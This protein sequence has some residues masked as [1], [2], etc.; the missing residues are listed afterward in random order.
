MGTAI[1]DSPL[2]AEPVR[3]PVYL[4]FSTPRRAA[5]AAGL[6]AAAGGPAHRRHGRID[7]TGV[8]NTFP[9]NPDLPLRSFT[10]AIDGGSGG[11]LQLGQDLCGPTTAD[12]DQGQADLALRQACREFKQELVDA[13]L[14]P[15]ARTCSAVKRGKFFTRGRRAALGRARGPAITSAPPGAARRAWC[16]ASARRAIHAGGRQ[17]RRQDDPK[18]TRREGPS[19]CRALGVSRS[20]GAAWLPSASSPRKVT[21]RFEAGRA[22]GPLRFGSSATR[23]ASQAS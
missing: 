3:G 11:L 16:A 17:D 1:I 22:R 21:V 10:L 8:R 23:L 5:G 7:P 20:S 14:R 12:R 4:A 19:R 6:P 15:A 9:A 2:Q 18:G 13:G